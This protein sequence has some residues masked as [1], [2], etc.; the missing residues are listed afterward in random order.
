MKAY[1]SF[2]VKP[3]SWDCNLACDYCFYKR[4]EDLYPGGERH[5]MDEE[6]F[7]A[8]VQQAQDE[9][10]RAVSYIW[11]GGE[12]MLMGLDFY[13]SAAAIQDE[14]R[15][16]GQTVTNTMQTNGILIDDDWAAF[17]AEKGI[18]VGISLDG[19]REVHDAHRFDAAGNSAFDR[20]LAACETMDRYGVEYNAL[21]VVTA[22]TAGSVRDTYHFLKERDLHFLQFI[23]CIEE[24][25]GDIA[26]F[27]VDEQTYG[28]FLCD[29][30][31][32]WVRDGYPYV[33]IRLFD[34][35]LQYMAGRSP[36]CCM[37]KDECGSYFVIEYNGDIYPCDFFV[38]DEWR[39]G[40]IRTDRLAD[41]IDG[42]L[43]RQFYELRSLPHEECE[44]CPWVGFCQRGCI[45]FRTFPD[46]DYSGKNHLC[47][48]YRMFF[49]HSAEAYR[50]L[51]WDIMR[52]HRGLPPPEIGRNDACPCGSGKKFKKC[53]G[54]Y[55]AVMKR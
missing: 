43:H 54:K 13:R 19:P 39:L 29:L 48:A 15:R 49:E 47:G 53:C 35:L 26:P 2:L 10:A 41:I 14:H 42:P 37:Y 40:N 24:T 45:K 31:D 32:E 6:T 46:G 34:N 8:L 3:A 52:R 12:P 23:D 38:R 7:R 1:R 17:F 36:E 21:A 51:S 33:S 25:G 50:F 11:Q 22:D 9:D 44:A 5:R 28:R 16:P 30:F 55:E 20:V 4:T 18:L 27:S